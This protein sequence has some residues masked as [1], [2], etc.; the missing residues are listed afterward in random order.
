MQLAE[1]GQ[2]DADCAIS[3]V[4]SVFK[5]EAGNG[6]QKLLRRRDE[7]TLISARQLLWICNIQSGQGREV[8]HESQIDAAGL[9]EQA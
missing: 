2:T 9:R 7:A 6:T 8:V 3:S 1:V 5:T 4:R